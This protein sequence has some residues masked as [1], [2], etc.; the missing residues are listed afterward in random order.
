MALH[1]I[2]SNPNITCPED[3]YTRAELA[4]MREISELEDELRALDLQMMDLDHRVSG[5]DM[6]GDLNQVR[7]LEDQYEVLI[8]KYS[9]IQER[10]RSLSVIA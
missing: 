5:A 2:T 4:Q 9:D 8:D 7:G 10:I 1:R 3:L 6:A